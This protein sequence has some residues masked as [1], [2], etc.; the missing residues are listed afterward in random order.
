LSTIRIAGSEFFSVFKNL[1]FLQDWGVAIK[2]CVGWEKGQ[3]R[4]KKQDGPEGG[5]RRGRKLPAHP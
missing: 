4:A 3:I 2:V 1:G 5:E